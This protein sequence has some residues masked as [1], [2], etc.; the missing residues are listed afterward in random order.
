MK[1]WLWMIVL[2]VVLGSL[3][4]LLVGCGG[5]STGGS[6]NVNGPDDVQRIDPEEAKALLDSG[7][8]VLYDAR[9]VDAYQTQ[10]A[11]G[12]VSFPEAEAAAH[13]DEL[14]D[15]GTALIFYCT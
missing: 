9:S 7:E 13:V 3:A 10:R 2:V 14:P 1:R 15:D 8:A 11:E 4:A 5:A 12:A 6:V